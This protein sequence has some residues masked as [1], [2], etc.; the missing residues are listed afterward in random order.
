MYA[1]CGASAETRLRL[2]RPKSLQHFARGRGRLRN[3][4]IN[5]DRILARF[6][7]QFPQ[8]R[9]AIH[10]EEFEVAFEISSREL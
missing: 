9:V 1:A 5:G 3:D 7:E 8:L 10:H 6:V 4:R 2:Y